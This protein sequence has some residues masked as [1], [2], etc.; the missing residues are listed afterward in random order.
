MEGVSIYPDIEE[1]EFGKRPIF[2]LVKTDRKV[3]KSDYLKGVGGSVVLPQTPEELEKRYQQYAKV[4]DVY[5]LIDCDC[6]QKE[7][8]LTYEIVFSCFEKASPADLFPMLRSYA[9]LLRKHS[10]GTFVSF[11]SGG[12]DHSL[13]GART[14]LERS[15]DACDMTDKDLFLDVLAEEFDNISGL[16]KSQ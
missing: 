9:T 14:M 10:S 13:S 7:G 2:R 6:F 15:R 3:M 1:T 11:F 4:G 5:K 8:F 16:F 12:L